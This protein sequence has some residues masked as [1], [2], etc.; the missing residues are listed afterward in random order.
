MGRAFGRTVWWEKRSDGRRERASEGGGGSDGMGQDRTGR[1][2]Y[3]TGQSGYDTGQS[4]YDTGG[5]GKR[6]RSEWE[7]VTRP[8]HPSL[9]TASPA[10]PTLASEPTT[11]AR[12]PGADVVANPLGRRAESAAP[13]ANGTPSPGADAAES[14]RRCGAIAGSTPLTRRT[15]EAASAPADM[16][17][18]AVRRMSSS[19]SAY[20]RGC[21]LARRAVCAPPRGALWWR[22]LPARCVA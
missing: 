8:A 13:I 7:A 16:T 3:D 12:S 18:S 11:L 6:S 14:R 20:L 19:C 1:S 5:H 17:T 15:V 22:M 2:G 21:E 9:C 4:G 10:T